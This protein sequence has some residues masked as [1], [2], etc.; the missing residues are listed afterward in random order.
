MF[1]G[2]DPNSSQASFAFGKDGKPS[3]ISGPYDNEDR[4]LRT[5][6]KT[7]GEGNFTFIVTDDQADFEEYLDK[8]D[9]E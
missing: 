8:E 9:S 4:I 3:Y 5:L 1:S 2:I 6:N 7:C